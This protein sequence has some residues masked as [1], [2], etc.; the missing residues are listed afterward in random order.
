MDKIFYVSRDIRLF[1]TE[2]Q[3][4]KDKPERSKIG[5]YTYF[6]S[7]TCE[8][9]RHTSLSLVDFKK[10]YGYIPRK[11]SCSRLTITIKKG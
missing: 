7:E 8:T 2:I 9:C 5:Y 11:G 6:V 10:L 4:W 3:I 1:N